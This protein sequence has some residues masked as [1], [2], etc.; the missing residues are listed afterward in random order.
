LHV[1]LIGQRLATRTV[2]ANAAGSWPLR[3]TVAVAVLS[4]LLFVLL[5]ASAGGWAPEASLGWTAIVAV[6][7]LA[8]AATLATYLP[9]P[10]AGR[11]LELGCTPCAVVAALSVLGAAVVLGTSP[12]DVSTAVLALVVVGFGLAQRLTNPS[13]CPAPGPRQ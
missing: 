10:G 11:K 7:A 8:A 2:F 12:Y 1:P 9:R 13:T 6:M 5:I 4:P 3:R